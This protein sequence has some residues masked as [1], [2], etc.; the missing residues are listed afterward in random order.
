MNCIRRLLGLLDLVLYNMLRTSLKRVT[1]G[2]LQGSPQCIARMRATLLDTISVT[3]KERLVT[4]H[5]PKRFL[6]VPSVGT[7]LHVVKS[8]LYFVLSDMLSSLRLHLE[9]AFDKE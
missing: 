9:I 3:L 6:H 2:L 7:V 4:L 8:A 5:N 1:A